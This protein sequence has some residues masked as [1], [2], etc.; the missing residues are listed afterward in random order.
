MKVKSLNRRQFNDFKNFQRLG[1]NP[2]KIDVR[3][4]TE[5]AEDIKCSLVKTKFL[6]LFRL[7]KSKTRKMIQELCR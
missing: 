3:R 2:N 5:P 1:E 6:K 7:K 4:L